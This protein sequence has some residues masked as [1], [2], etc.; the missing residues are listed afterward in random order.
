MVKIASDVC[1]S[2]PGA[3]ICTTDADHEVLFCLTCRKGWMY[4]Q[5]R[6]SY[7]KMSEDNS[8]YIKINCPKLYTSDCDVVVCPACFVANAEEVGTVSKVDEDGD[9]WWREKEKPK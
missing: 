6:R 5:R 2:C 7:T 1:H 3:L 9:E 4:V 8:M